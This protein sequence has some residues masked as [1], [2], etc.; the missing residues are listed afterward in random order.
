MIAKPRAQKAR[1]TAKHQELFLAMMP[2]ITEA[3]RFAFKDQD[4]EA[5][6][7]ATAEV[8]A[9]ALLMFVK[10]GRADL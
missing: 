8:V 1:L 2:K 10:E 6:D 3:A 5:R 9:S 7:D 4:P